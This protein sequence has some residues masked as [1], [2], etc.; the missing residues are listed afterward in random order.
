M[1]NILLYFLALSFAVGFQSCSEDF[2][3]SAPYKDVTIA[4]GLLNMRDT[5]HYI[6][7]QKAFLDENKS[8]FDMAKEPDSNFFRQLDVKMKE[9]SGGSTV[10][11]INLQR[12]DLANE[13]YPKTGGSFFTS[14]NYA[15]KFK[16]PLNP[17]Y[18]YRLVIT[19][20]ETGAMDSS[21]INI[22]DSGKL[23]VA[24]F[25]D[26]NFRLNFGRTTPASSARFQLFVNAAP[27]SR[28]IEGIIRFH[29]VD[30]NVNTG[31]QTEKSTDFVFA[32]KPVDNKPL[33]VA[34]ISIYTALRDAML[35]APAG[36]ERY[37]DSCEVLVYA[38]G[39]DF[40]NYM[41]ATQIQSSGLTA[42]QLKPLYTNFKGKD[43]YGIFSS[44]TYTVRKNVP[45]ESSTLDSLKISPITSSL[46]IKGRSDN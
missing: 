43:I 41:V 1:K 39:P 22:L 45:I 8:A 24:V 5:A 21:E 11:V 37:M 27:N 30:K 6:R 23:S 35:A 20:T 9:M 38:A 12:V 17:A 32:S 3:V 19:H 36:I 40:Y 18:T 16:N 29:W 14:P 34:N 42:D 31:E 7:I 28:Y 10:N 44:R 25:N 15:Y 2:E 26:A 4:Y 13:G 33:D 46:N